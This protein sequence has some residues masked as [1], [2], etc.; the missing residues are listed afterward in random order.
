M[1]GFGRTRLLPGVVTEKEKP[2]SVPAPPKR[3]DLSRAGQN[4]GV[5]LDDD[6]RGIGPAT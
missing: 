4:A 2:A 1:P 5:E 3:P 6:A